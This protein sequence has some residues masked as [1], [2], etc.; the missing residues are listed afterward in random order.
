L[1]LWI[2]R[3]VGDLTRGELLADHRSAADQHCPADTAVERYDESIPP[4]TL[5]EPAEPSREEVDVVAHDGRHAGAV[6]DRVRERDLAPAQPI[7]YE[8]S[9]LI[10]DEAGRGDADADHLD[11]RPFEEQLGEGHDAF[12]VVL[13]V[14]QIDVDP[15]AIDDRAVHV[16]G[17]ADEGV[18]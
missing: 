6:G 14:L 16:D 1:A 12:D 17:R 9:A 7:R 13:P 8:H 3:E 18:V 10:V 4:R 11:A 2:D 15:G 5:P